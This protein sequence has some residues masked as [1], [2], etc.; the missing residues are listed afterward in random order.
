MAAYLGHVASAAVG[1]IPED[2]LTVL[3]SAGDDPS[4]FEDQKGENWSLVGV[5]Q[6]LQYGSRSARPDGDGPVRVSAEDVAVVGEG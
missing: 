4:V 3:A 5:A 1:G 2:E 6:D